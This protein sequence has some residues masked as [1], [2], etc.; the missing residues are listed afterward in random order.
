MSKNHPRILVVDDRAENR[1]VLCRLLSQAGFDCT[2]IGTG[3]EA[4]AMA[5]SL[6]DLLILDV[7]LPDISGY[8][9]CRRIKQ[10]PHTS[11]ISILQI[12]ASF[13][14]SEDRARALEAG[15][16]GY[17]THPIEPMVL[18]ATVR[19][20]LRLR[21]AESIARKSAE[22]WQSTFDALSEGLAL[23][24]GEC[25][26]VRWN[27]AFE[28]I[29]GAGLDGELNAVFGDD[30][31]ALLERILGSSEALRHSGPE[32]F[33]GEYSIQQRTV[34]LTVNQVD[35]KNQ[36]SG[37]VL[38]L[39]DITDSKL[40]E[41]A[42][43][44]AEKIAAT[45]KLAHAI[46]HEINNPLEALT[47][48]LYLA[49]ASNNTDAIK[50]LLA[51]A[52]AEVERIARITRQT[53]SFQRDTRHPVVVDVGELVSEVVALYQRTAAARR[54]RVV[55]ECRPTLA[56]RGFPGQLRQIFSNLIRN[57][58]EAAPPGTEVVVRV[59][60]ICRHG[61]EGARITIHDRGTGIPLDVRRQIFDPFFTTKE[62]KGSGLG[63]WVSR[64]LVMDHHGTIRFRTSTREG[65]SGT[66]FEVFLPVGG[67]A[68]NSFQSDAA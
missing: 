11:Q 3:A 9:V 66:T 44:T 63:L 4:L 54:V 16:D 22:Q 18:I 38:V 25:R 12:S 2:E 33:Q 67:M 41:Y 64:N 1:Y 6:P 47:N 49:G 43:R 48:L 50:E 20:L 62:L 28:E 58:A 61:H 40:A 21:T 27:G 8:E 57:A 13:V 52:S 65:A 19:A 42:L 68:Q 15:A 39:S 14:S 32:R 35:P 24:D 7:N 34:Q 56:I 45:G 51:H 29:C 30:A 23:V 59:R 26:L 55:C 17:L 10:D 31:C 37:R 60:S 46:A 53:L 5:R 36:E